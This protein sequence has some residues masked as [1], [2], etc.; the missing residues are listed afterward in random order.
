[1]ERPFLGTA[2][3]ETRRAKKPAHPNP[4]PDSHPHPHPHLPPHPHPHPHPHQVAVKEGE[5]AQLAGLKAEWQGYRK[6][7]TEVRYLVI[8][9]S[10]IVEWQG[11]RKLL[12]EVG[13]L[14]PYPYPHR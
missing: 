8:T 12:T 1:M 9:P 11:Y 3:P 10:Y 5:L 6:L 13:S 14:L 7:L 4:D 2:T